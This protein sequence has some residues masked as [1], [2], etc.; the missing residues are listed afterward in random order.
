MLIG[1]VTVNSKIKHQGDVHRARYMPQEVRQALSHFC[2]HDECAVCV[3]LASGHQ[4][5]F[6]VCAHLHVGQFFVRLLASQIQ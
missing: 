2:M 3:A 1:I 6:A 5:Q 4:V